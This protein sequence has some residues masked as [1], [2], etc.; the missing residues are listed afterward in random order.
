[1]QLPPK[2]I[3][4]ESDIAPLLSAFVAEKQRMG[5]KYNTIAAYLKSFDTYLLDKSCK[6][7]LSKELMLDWVTPKPHQTSTTVEHHIHIMQRLAD[8]LN[9]NGFSAYRIPSE[10]IPKKTHHF[11]PYVFS[12]EEI[13]SILTV[14]DGFEYNKTSPKRHL[15]YPLLFRVLCFCGLR[16]SEALNLMVGDVNFDEGFFFLRDTKTSLDR[17]IPLDRNLQ[18]RFA[19][20]MEQM[21]FQ[22]KDEYFFPSPD[23][24]RYSV[25]TMDS[26]FRGI[27]FKAGIPYRGKGKGP[28]LHDLR[29]TFC[30]HSLQKLTAHGED[31]YAV[32]PLLMTYM[33]HRSVQATSQYIHLSAESFPAILKRSEALFGDLIPLEDISNEET[34]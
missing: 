19:S 11:T 14:V 24:S 34:I 21:G 6:D 1:M 9:R 10:L 23:G 33:G 25:A 27:L 12:Y 17:I 20:Y 32:L 15:V 2:P 28:R 13:A 4:F 26:T 22:R 3:V 7:A 31:P 8:F 18:D 16:I 29:H 5:F 30:V